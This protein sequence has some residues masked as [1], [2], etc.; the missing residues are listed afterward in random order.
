M[1]PKLIRRVVP[2][3]LKRAYRAALQKPDS[4]QHGE[5]TILRGLCEQ[6]ECSTFLVDVGAHDGVSFSNSLPFVESGWKGIL[7]E[8]SPA[9]FEKLKAN[10]ATRRN[11]TC[12]H[13]ACSDRPGEA[14]LHIGTDGGGGFLSTIC[15]DENEWFQ[16]AR[17]SQSITVRADT[18]TN[19]LAAES[20][21]STLGILL[22]DAEGMDYEVLLGLDF[23][24]FRPTFIV[25][26]EYEL[27]A[28]KH[29]RKY[30]LLIH[31]GYS[32]QQKIGC[33]TIWMDRSARMRPVS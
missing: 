14:H 20:A 7:I 28:D 4:S 2:S 13:A 21:P 10:H 1:I 23:S 11:V 5:V 24:R 15:T 8:A 25:T 27:N 33:N 19:I 22:V 32:L 31:L 17:S 26:E 16:K 6:F 12:I 30:A 9:I 29:A 18:L 3:Q